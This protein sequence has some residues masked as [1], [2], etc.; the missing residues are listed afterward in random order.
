MLKAVDT[1]YAKPWGREKMVHA[2][3]WE[4]CRTDGTQVW[5]TVSEDRL[6]CP[7]LSIILGGFS[8]AQWGEAE[9]D[10]NAF[11]AS[12]ISRKWCKSGIWSIYDTRWWCFGYLRHVE[13]L[14]KI[15]KRLDKSTAVFGL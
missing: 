6:S 13:E 2:A 4:Q 1:G 11:Y 7:N 5:K 14:G 3:T 12:A 15:N 8:R 9:E 10:P